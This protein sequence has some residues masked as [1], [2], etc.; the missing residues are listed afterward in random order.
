[1]WWVHHG[2]VLM[3]FWLSGIAIEGLVCV[4]GALWGCAN[5][6]LFIRHCHRGTGLYGGRY[7]DVLMCVCLSG[8]AIE[9]LACVVGAMGMC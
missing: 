9:G 3:C 8:I 4:V 1:M 2:D 7:G 6:C 5:V